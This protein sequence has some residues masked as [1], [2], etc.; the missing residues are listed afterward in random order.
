MKN[1][2]LLKMMADDIAK[3]G[4]REVYVDILTAN[5]SNIQKITG[6]YSGSSKVT[7]DV[8]VDDVKEF[9]KSIK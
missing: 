2:E 3:Y 1:I 7:I 6:L 8:D 5:Q 9:K 4:E